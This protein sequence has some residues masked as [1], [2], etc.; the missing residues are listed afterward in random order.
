MVDRCNSKFVHIHVIQNLMFTAKYHPCGN[1]DYGGWFFCK[2]M[3]TQKISLLPKF[4]A[5]LNLKMNS[6]TMKA[7]LEKIE[8]TKHM[9]F[10]PKLRLL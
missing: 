7:K 6:F 3:K 9:F 2:I 10:S 4:Y 1:A 5:N 8:E